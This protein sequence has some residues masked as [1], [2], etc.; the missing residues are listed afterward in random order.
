MN[1]CHC[2]DWGVLFLRL[3]FGP[4]MLLAHG[5]PKIQNYEKYSQGFPD[6]LGFGH[7][8]SLILGIFTE[9]ILSIFLT[10]GL[11][12]RFSALGLIITMLVIIFGVHLN[13]PWHKIEFA[14]LYLLPYLSIFISGAGKFSIDQKIFNKT[15]CSI[16]EKLVKP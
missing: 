4:M 1:N 7:E 10:L 2:K 15:S 9:V 6:P 14:L 5:I 12:T 13:D 3:S 11:F 8:F 16:I